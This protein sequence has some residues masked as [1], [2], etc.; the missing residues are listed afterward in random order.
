MKVWIEGCTKYGTRVQVPSLPA[1]CLLFPIL[2]PKFEEIVVSKSVITQHSYDVC[3]LHSEVVL[4]WF[5]MR[6][7][8][9]LDKQMGWGGNVK[10]QALM[11]KLT[12]PGFASLSRLM[13]YGREIKCTVPDICFSFQGGRN[14]KK[15]QDSSSSVQYTSSHMKVFCLLLSTNPKKRQKQQWPLLSIMCVTRSDKSYFLVP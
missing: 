4:S 10:E 12:W 3:Y 8:M 9:D 5:L 1:H 11:L 7:Q 14:A 2:S 15:K 6:N 13:S